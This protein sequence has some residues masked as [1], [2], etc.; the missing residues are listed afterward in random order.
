MLSGN[1]G[2]GILS[3]LTE[4]LY[5]KPI[6]VF[7]EYVQNSVDSFDKIENKTNDDYLESRIWK[8]DANLYFLDNG[9]GIDK[10]AFGKEMVSIADSKK[11]RVD[12]IGYK[13]IGRLSGLPY[14]DRLT[15][16]NICSYE[17]GQFQSFTLDGK[18]YNQIKN[19]SSFNKLKFEEAI[20]Q[21]STFSY[22]LTDSDFNKIKPIIDSSKELFSIQDTG[23][24]V[25]LENISPILNQT[26]EGEQE[27][28]FL[29]ELGWLLPVK[30]KDELFQT[31]QAELFKE[32]TEKTAT[33]SNII[34][35]KA[36][37]ISFNNKQI[38]RPISSNMLRDYTCKAKFAEYAV[39]FHSFY[40][41][42]IAVIR[43][44]E[45]SGI[46]LYL[47]NILLCDETELIPIL[48]RYGLVNRSSHELVQTVKGLG[49]IIYITDKI[50]I[51]ANARRTF[52]EVTDTESLE[53]L[54]LLAEFVE[55]IYNARYALSK[56]ASAKKDSDLS[57][58]K[59]HELRITANQALQ[60]LAKEEITINLEDEHFLKFEDKTEIE[61]KQII[62]S[63]L[64]RY[65]NQLIKEYLLQTR[66]FD[67]DNSVSDFQKWLLSNLE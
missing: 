22:E 62:K 33:E 31:A 1:V 63:K 49:S 19:Q 26:I 14:C 10:D 54:E 36:Y 11:R 43:G 52:I 42:K 48:R 59:L 65:S 15:F 16:I 58:S 57:Y 25:I 30:F 44:N 56:Y 40:R 46:R 51:K 67:Y 35:A 53:L 13:G 24:L 50:N 8:I 20:S 4:S 37:N 27:D 7:R 38:E 47:D 64:T 17:T 3:I 23:F 5:D 29:T 39:G 66:T 61:Q 9:I 2:A 21:I 12:D 45:F 18:K 41:N 34:P 6:V 55:T 60:T 28:D 32:M